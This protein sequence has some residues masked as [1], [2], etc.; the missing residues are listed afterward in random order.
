MVKSRLL[1]SLLGSLLTPVLSTAVSSAALPAPADGP[2]VMRRAPVLK[3]ERLHN[4]RRQGSAFI[5][6]ETAATID[7]AEVIRSVDTLFQEAASSSESSKEEKEAATTAGRITAEFLED[8]PHD[9]DRFPLVQPPEEP[10]DKWIRMAREG[11]RKKDLELL[12]AAD[13]TAGPHAIDG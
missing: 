1:L 2:S 4:L 11:Y 8:P 9:T 6:D 12:M 13:E 7:F 3:Q 5:E 10:E